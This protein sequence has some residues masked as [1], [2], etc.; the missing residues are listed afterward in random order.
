MM[1]KIK[2]CEICHKKPATIPDRNRPGR[3][4]NK[5]CSKCHERKLRKD[6]EYVSRYTRDKRNSTKQSS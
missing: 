6:L 5:I 2:L 4:I 3:L 1:N